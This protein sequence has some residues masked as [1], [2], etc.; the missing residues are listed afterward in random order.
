MTDEDKV[1]LNKMNVKSVKQLEGFV[2][3][4][5]PTVHLPIVPEKCLFCGAEWRWCRSA[6]ETISQGR[7]T[8]ILSMLF[9]AVGVV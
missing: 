4:I 9:F 6:R 1:K 5:T 7:C 3:D 2:D 8:R